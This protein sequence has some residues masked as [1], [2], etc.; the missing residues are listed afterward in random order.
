MPQ[1]AATEAEQLAGAQ[2]LAALRHELGDSDADEADGDGNGNGSE[3]EEGARAPRVPRHL[4]YE[5]VCVLRHAAADPTG[6]R[7]TAGARG[8]DV[9]VVGER[10]MQCKPVAKDWRRGAEA[11]E[12]ASAEKAN[13]IHALIW[14][15][16]RQAAE[17]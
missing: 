1:E 6:E 7:S 3:A 14:E 8:G 2:E 15:Q 10:L 16:R 5:C 11:E 4:K 9:D 12:K 13:A 17:R